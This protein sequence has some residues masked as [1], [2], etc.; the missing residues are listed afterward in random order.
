[1]KSYLKG[2]GYE[3]DVIDDVIEQ[4]KEY[5]YIDDYQFAEMYFAYGFE[6]GRGVSRIR[7]ELAEKGV[8]S[9]I[10]DMVY[11]DLEE[12]PD[13]T[14][15]AMEIAEPMVSG[16]DIDELDYDAKQKLKAKIG[17]RLMSRGFNSDV[18]FKVIGRLV[19]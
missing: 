8:S 18:A 9:D 2:K 1:M 12:M 15:M 16:I 10:I 13:E 6:K 4:M 5:H 14:E 19:K 11:E 7:R 17:R 3:E